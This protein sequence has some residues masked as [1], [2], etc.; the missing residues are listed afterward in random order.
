MHHLI[1][2]IIT[3]AFST[4][5]GAHQVYLDYASVLGSLG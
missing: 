2:H 5:F 3:A 4:Y 1:G